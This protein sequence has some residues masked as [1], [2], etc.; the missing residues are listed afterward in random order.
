MGGELTKKALHRLNKTS[1]LGHLAKALLHYRV[2]KF[3]IESLNFFQLG[4]LLQRCPAC[5]EGRCIVTMDGNFRLG[6]RMKASKGDDYSG[7]RIQ[8]FFLDPNETK[9]A[10]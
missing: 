3:S 8:Y 5:P 2:L 7:L 9:T 4:D 1:L 10:T 6:R